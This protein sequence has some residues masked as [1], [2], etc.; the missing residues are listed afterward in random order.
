MRA[1]LWVD[2]IVYDVG[3][4]GFSA[5]CRWFNALCGGAEASLLGVYGGGG[6]AC[7]GGVNSC[8]SSIGYLEPAFCDCCLD[9]PYEILLVPG[10]KTWCAGMRPYPFEPR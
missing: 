4:F 7:T 10:P 2:M 9:P 8:G 1:G 6:T 5:G 3:W